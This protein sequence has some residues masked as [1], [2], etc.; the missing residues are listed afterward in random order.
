M[1]TTHFGGK[2]D[3]GNVSRNILSVAEEAGVV[4]Q[5][6]RSK[7]LPLTLSISTTGEAEVE[8]L[9]TLEAV[10]LEKRVSTLKLHTEQGTHARQCSNR[11]PS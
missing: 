5:S 3:A 9:R 11:V 10:S 4:R 6:F 7:I 2:F 8:L 1:N